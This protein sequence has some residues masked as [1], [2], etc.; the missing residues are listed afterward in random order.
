MPCVFCFW[1][2]VNIAGS[3][4]EQDTGL[5]VSD[6]AQ[7]DS[8]FYIQDPTRLATTATKPRPA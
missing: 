5:G 6:E 4:N 1:E 3:I 7:H 2:Q 8:R